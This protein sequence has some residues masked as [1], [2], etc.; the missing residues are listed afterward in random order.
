VKA[1]ALIGSASYDPATLQVIYKSFDDAWEQVK[2]QISLRPE[3]IE[4]GRMKLAEIILSLARNGT[5]D[6][7]ALTD[8]AVCAMLAA[9]TALRS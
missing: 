1:R 8:A 9:P 4:A 2:P 7:Q 6:A 3:A 5:L